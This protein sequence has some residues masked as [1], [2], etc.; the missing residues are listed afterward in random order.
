MKWLIVFSGLVLSSCTQE[1][2]Q[3]V[4]TLVNGYGCGSCHVIPSIPGATGRTG[5]P[6]QDYQRQVYVAGVLP[7]TH[8][9]LTRFI[10]DPQTVDPRSA[11]PDLGVTSDE[12]SLL[13]SYLRAEP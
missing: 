8:E 3:T 10:M 7:N 6:L 4:T 2:P 1:A 9:T 5:P 12:A 13:A 11:M